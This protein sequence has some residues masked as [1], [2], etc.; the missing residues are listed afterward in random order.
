[1][2]K[3]FILS[4]FLLP[5]FVNA[6][7]ETYRFG[8]DVKRSETPDN[9]IQGDYYIVPVQDRLFTSQFNKYFLQYN[10]MS[11]E[12]MRA[13]FQQNLN[14]YVYM[15]LAKHTSAVDAVA[16]NDGK[17]ETS[18]IYE[19]VNFS[20]ID[21]P[22]EEEEETKIDQLKNKFK[23][24]DKADEA[25]KGTYVAQ[26]QLVTKRDNTPKYLDA[27]V[28]DRSFLPLIQSFHA[29]KYIVML[30]QLELVYPTNTA[31]LDLQY[32]RFQREI[33][34]HYTVVDG[35]GTKVCGGLATTYFSP[36]L[37]DLNTIVETHFPEIAKQ[38]VMNIPAFQ[39]VY[40]TS[41]EEK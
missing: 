10:D 2:R 12:D 25:P 18:L 11:F 17:R 32:E 29:T 22:V 6:Q 5:L 4:L 3:I 40:E 23:K 30:N 28:T 36:E 19:N 16:L 27:E 33:K 20:Y 1:M 39:D 41:S 14:K 8:D 26:G 37:N 13:F 38:I 24:K 34:V 21:L 31:Q 9:T 35:S 15:E 7:D